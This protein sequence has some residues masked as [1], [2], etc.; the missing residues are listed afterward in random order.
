[1]NPPTYMGFRTSRYGP[2]AT[3]SAGRV[4]RRRRTPPSNDEGADAGERK[5]SAGQHEQNSRPYGDV[6]NRHFPKTVVMVT[7]DGRH[8]SPEQSESAYIKHGP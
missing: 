4:E 8:P 7:D 5:R 6:W 1:M 2:A 3:N